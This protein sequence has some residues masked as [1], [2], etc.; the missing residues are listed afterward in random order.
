MLKMK[1]WKTTRI[2]TN[3]F[4]SWLLFKQIYLSFVDKY[5]GQSKRIMKV[6]LLKQIFL[7]LNK[8]YPYMH[9]LSRHQVTTSEKK[10]TRVSGLIK[11][12]RRG[13]ISCIL[14]KCTMIF[15][16]KATIDIKGEI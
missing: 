11:E 13:E 7:K 12:S 6:T 2:K 9:L 5:I 4:L 10:M 1:K 8:F 16:E 3:Q 14:K 15:L